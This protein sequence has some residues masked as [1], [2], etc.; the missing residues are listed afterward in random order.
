MLRFRLRKCA[1]DRT[2][3]AM[4]PLFKRQQRSPNPHP[5]ARL[6]EQLRDM[7]GVRRGNLHHRFFR[8]DRQERLVGDDM[9]ARGHVPRNDLG[10]L[11]TFTKVRKTEDRHA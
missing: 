3:L 1:D 10:L 2:R 7:A 8:F 11:K 5:V 9:I 4:R 6:C